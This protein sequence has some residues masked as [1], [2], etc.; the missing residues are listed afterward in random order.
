M[1]QNIHM[2]SYIDSVFQ[3][4]KEILDIENGFA[5]HL[6]LIDRLLRLIFVLIPEGLHA[7]LHLADSP[8]LIHLESEIL[9]DHEVDTRLGV[10]DLIERVLLLPL[11]DVSEL[12]RL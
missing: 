9:I 10:L 1:H 11:L 8:L 5:D 4:F 3:S 2:G 12:D 7:K 6:L